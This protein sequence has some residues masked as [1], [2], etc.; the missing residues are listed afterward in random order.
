MVGEGKGTKKVLVYVI[1]F[2]FAFITLIPFLWM[3]STS[4]KTQEEMFRSSM[5]II[6][7]TFNFKNYLWA[8]EKAPF[9][10]YVFNSIFVSG[11]TTLGVI[12]TSL[13]AGFALSRIHFPFRNG[14]FIIIL[15]T[16]MI[17]H[18][19]IMIPS[20]I[21]LRNFGWL[22]TYWALT[23]P[24]LVYPF[25]VFIIRNFFIG[26]PKELEEAANLDGCSRL[27]TLFRIFVPISLPAIASVIIFNFTYIWNDF[28]WPLVMTKSV[29]LRT[30]Q[31]GLAML[32]SEFLLQWPFLMAGT[33]IASIPMFIVFL[34]FQ[35]FFVKGTVSSGVKG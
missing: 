9:L 23:V 1:A 21:L 35:N 18:Q 19:S 24:F 32:Q 3:L 13:L 12:I 14:L 28:F 10:R 31:V 29:D 30:V 2:V 26:I 15:A 8:F 4:L 27:Q 16:M 33:V 7:E 25:A 20:F 11:I 6:P 17:P 5:S 34:A 22:D